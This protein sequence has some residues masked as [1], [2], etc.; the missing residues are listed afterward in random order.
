[1]GD[2]TVGAL[3]IQTDG[4]AN[5]AALGTNFT[6]MRVKR[7]ILRRSRIGGIFTGR[8]V[9]T[10]GSGSNEVFG[11]DATLSFYDNL[12]FNG[13]YARSKTPGLSGNDTSYQ[14]AFTYNGD[15]Y[16]FQ[17]D[18]LLV[19]DNFNPEIGFLRRDDFRRTFVTSQYS[20]RPRAIETVRQFTWGGE[21]KR[22]IESEDL[23]R[24]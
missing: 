5:G 18:H 11:L 8:S 9:S 6:V 14:A 17:V 22:S 4:G 20:P 3:N 23:V 2:F 1:M 12:N 13:Y 16:A 7:D 24:A 19:G 10:K 15:R 21:R